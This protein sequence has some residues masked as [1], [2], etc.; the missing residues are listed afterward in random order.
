M[1]D[2]LTLRHFKGKAQIPPA[3]WT[4]LTSFSTDAS[5]DGFGAVWRSRTLAGLFLGEQEDLDINKKEMLIVMAGIKHWFA[6][7]A[8][9]RVK[10]FIDNKVCVSLL[11]YGITRSPFL[12]ACLREIQFYLASFD[13]ELR[14]EYIPSKSNVLADLCSRAYSTDNHFK[15]FNKLLNNGTL[16]LENINYKK[17]EFEYGF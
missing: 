7:L 12:A 14:A 2:H 4:P 15:E 5:L 17:F 13:I 8:N 11:N 9:L 6:D 1:V 3:V 10:I 16:V